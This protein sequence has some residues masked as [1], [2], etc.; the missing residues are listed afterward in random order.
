MN[1]IINAPRQLKLAVAVL[2]AAVLLLALLAVTMTAGPTMAQNDGNNGQQNGDPTATPE[3]TATATP[4]PTPTPYPEPQPC[5]PGQQ[6]PPD[7]EVMDEIITEG[8]YG[9]FDGYWDGNTNTLNLN[10]CPP[11]VHHEDVTDLSTG[12]TTEVSHRSAS[13]IYIEE[14]VFEIDHIDGIPAERQ[15]EHVLTEADV[16]K[17]DFL[18]LH[19]DEDGNGVD[20]A[21]G[22]TVWWLKVEDEHEGGHDHE[23]EE[24]PLAMGFSA[25]LF[26]SDYWYRDDGDA[27]KYDEGL[28]PLQYEFEVIREPG[29]PAAEYG[30]VFAFDDSDPPAGE[31]KTAYWDSSEPDANALPLYPGEYHH[32]QWIFTKQA[33]YNIWVQLKGHVRQTN[34]HPVGHEDYD[35]DWKPISDNK[36]ETSVVKQYTFQVGPLTLNHEPIFEVRRSVDENSSAGTLVGDPIPAYQ[37]DSDPVYFELSGTGYS[38]FDVENVG[39]NAQIKV[40]D[41]A[42]LNFEELPV[43]RLTLGLT[44]DKDHEDNYHPEGVVVIDNTIS[45]RIALND[46]PEESRSVRENSP[47]GTLVGDPIVVPG[48]DSGDSYFLVGDDA[49]LFT[50]EKDTNNNAQIKVN[51]ALDFETKGSYRVDL[52]INGNPNEAGPID[53]TIE[54]IDEEELSVAENSDV[55][56]VVGAP[57]AVPDADADTAYTLHDDDNPLTSDGAGLFTV[58]NSGGDAQIKVNGALDYET[59]PNSYQ[60]VLR[61]TGF[62]GDATLVEDIPVYIQIT[63][64]ADD[65]PGSFTVELRQSYGVGTTVIIDAEAGNLPANLA[66]DDLN[67]LIHEWKDGQEKGVVD[68]G[69]ASWSASGDVAL[70]SWTR[71]LAPGTWNYQIKVWYLDE[72]RNR[73]TVTSDV[74]RVVTSN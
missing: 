47:V 66:L 17:Y 9:V 63:D 21:V 56:T 34:P 69:T 60:I 20:D 22:T 29:I 30:H 10:L 7:Y 52:E 35:A 43:Y 67:Q 27:D 57:I 18:K 49:R 39:G 28:K 61:A 26:S 36:V 16:E 71:N 42:D 37:G 72:G 58:E 45:V 6:E 8:H 15:F 2:A 38:H 53:I 64:V 3:P 70:L 41:G 25:A 40:K 19:V 14:T 1:T 54:I 32:F 11:R 23:E 51:G 68:L 50:V 12:V 33:T 55:G 59:P 46:L 48:A 65:V 4:A 24:S 73:I 13:N 44:D 74:L 31:D 5:G 62:P